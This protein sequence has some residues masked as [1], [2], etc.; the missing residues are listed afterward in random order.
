V[1]RGDILG[2]DNGEFII[3]GLV[4]VA[5]NLGKQEE[6]AFQTLLILDGLRGIDST[7]MVVIGRGGEHKMAKAVGNP[8]DLIMTKAYDKALIGMNRVIIGHNRFAT[9]GRPSKNNAHPFEFSNIVGAH[10]GTLKSKHKLID[11]SE[12]EVD[13]ANLFHHINEKGLYSA[14]EDL[15]GAWA[16]VWWDNRDDTL[17]FLRNKERPLFMTKSNTGCLFW[18]SEKWMLD[19]ALSRNAIKHEDVISLAEDTHLSFVINDAGFVAKP[20]AIEMKS[21]AVPFTSTTTPTYTIVQ[22]GQTVTRQVSNT[23]AAAASVSTGK[24]L[25]R[26]PVAI[27]SSYT[28]SRDVC[29]TITGSNYTLSGAQYYTLLDQKNPCEY[30]RLFK[31]PKDKELAINSQILA[32]IGSKQMDSSTGIH[33]HKVEYSSVRSMSPTNETDKVYKN[34]YGKDVTANEFYVEHGECGICTG[35]VDPSNHKFTKDGTAICHECCSDA[36]LTEFINLR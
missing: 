31:K 24:Q 29:L 18:A 36:S 17:N 27:A 2:T 11:S 15:D 16:L 8:Y 13:S 19:V 25:I 5:G 20:H 34:A 22:N 32:D 12:F 1:Q 30:I 6:D 9:Q 7:G 10:N 4:G 23:P 21:R 28:G 3:C 26:K 14:M 33:Y 35:F